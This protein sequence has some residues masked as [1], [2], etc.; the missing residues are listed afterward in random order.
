MEGDFKYTAEEYL[1]DWIHSFPASD[2]CLGSEADIFA[3]AS[4]F[5]A[6]YGWCT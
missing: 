3:E 1:R 6:S 2:P 5:F 4:L